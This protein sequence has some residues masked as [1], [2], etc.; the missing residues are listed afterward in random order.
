MAKKVENTTSLE[1]REEWMIRFYNLMA[2]KNSLNWTR[3]IDKN[4]NLFSF[5]R[6]EKR[7][8][9]QNQAIDRDFSL[10]RYITSI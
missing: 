10:L 4:K 2:K 6:K 5:F 1:F 9:F 7:I 8:C 3:K